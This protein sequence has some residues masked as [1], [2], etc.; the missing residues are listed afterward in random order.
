LNEGGCSCT[1]QKTGIWRVCLL[2]CP[3]PPMPIVL[4]GRRALLGV[5][6]SYF[7][8]R[9]FCRNQVILVTSTDIIIKEIFFWSWR[10]LWILTHWFIP[11]KKWIQAIRSFCS[12]LLLFYS[13][14][15]FFHF[16]ELF[17]LL[18][19]FYSLFSLFSLFHLF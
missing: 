5:D 7:E 16:I 15:H 19:L 6:V 1:T 8:D 10:K 13:L 18:L 14:F 4:N 11:L 3:T 12:L 2:C 17:S 9:E